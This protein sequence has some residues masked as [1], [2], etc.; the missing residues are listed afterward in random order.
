VLERGYS[1]TEGANRAIVRD[2]SRLALDEEIKITFARGW[3]G[4]Q[5]RRKG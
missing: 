2:G 5:V 4:A 1:I 3:V